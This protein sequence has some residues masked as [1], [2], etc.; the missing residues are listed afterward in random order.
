[1]KL[2]DEQDREVGFETPGELLLQGPNLMMGYWRNEAATT[3][4]TLTPDGW[5]RTGDVAIVHRDGHLRLVDRRKELIKVNAL[6]VAPAKLE[7]TLLGN[8]H[9]ADCAVVGITIDDEERPRAY[10]LLTEAAVAKG[11]TERDV[12]LWLQSRVAKH[13]ALVG[14]VK[15]VGEIVSLSPLLGPDRDER[16]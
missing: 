13:K 11:V 8:E 4:E 12:Q 9:V 6:Q 5:L 3:R 2:V 14:G 15:F 7:G 10:V 1:M 16:G